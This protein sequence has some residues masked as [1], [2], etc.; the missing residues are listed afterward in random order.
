M[1]EEIRIYGKGNNSHDVCNVIITFECFEW[2]HRD[3]DFQEGYLVMHKVEIE[4]TCTNGIRI[5][6]PL[7]DSEMREHFES[8]LSVN[9]CGYEVR[10]GVAA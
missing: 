2:S 7:D 3:T 9:C 5:P 4:P 10:T 6:C 1:L 8:L